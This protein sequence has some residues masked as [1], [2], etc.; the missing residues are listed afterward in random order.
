M[1]TQFLLTLLLWLLANPVWALDET[2]TGNYAAVHRDGHTTDKV[3]RLTRTGKLWH[4]AEQKTNGTWKEIACE[5]DCTMREST[6][7]GLAKLFPGADL[8][9][10]A[11][12]C[13]ENY[14]F[15][16][17]SYLTGTAGVQSSYAL[18]ARVTPGPVHIRLV[19]IPQ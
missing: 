17:C 6:S 10:I 7:Y 12:S 15:A 18:V 5:G 19:R 8:A 4:V 14:A 11:P 13:V 1:R 16:F 9:K 3:F 2:D